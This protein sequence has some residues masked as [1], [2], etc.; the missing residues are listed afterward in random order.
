[1][2]QNM[3]LVVIPAFNS[4][5]TIQFSVESVLKQTHKNIKVI[6]VDDCSEDGTVNLLKSIRNC[7]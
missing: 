3:I 4:E 7:F 1:M 2:T 6:V 5:K